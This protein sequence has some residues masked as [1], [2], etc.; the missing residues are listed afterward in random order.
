MS[1]L[2]ISFRIMLISSLYLLEMPV[3]IQVLVDYDAHRFPL[4]ISHLAVSDY[5]INS[6]VNELNVVKQLL[7]ADEGKYDRSEHNDHEDN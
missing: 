4:C 5:K 7:N 6:L 1:Q 3:C 2:V